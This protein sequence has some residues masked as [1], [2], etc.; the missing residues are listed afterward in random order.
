MM[1]FNS[2]EELYFSWFLDDLIK[3]GII[4]RYL[5]ESNSFILS[6]R[7]S[8]TYNKQLVTK[9]KPIRLS[10]LDEHIYTPDFLVEWNDDYYGIFFR[11]I[12]SVNC[13]TKPPFFSVRSK[14]NNLPYTF[15]EVK[16]NFDRNNMT[17]LFRINQKWLYDKHG[18]YVHLVTIPDLFKRMFIPER[19]FKTDS[20]RQLRKINFGIKK[21]DE[22]FMWLKNQQYARK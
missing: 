19:Y 18:L 16:G 5:Y 22:Y 20:N 13:F 7:K 3:H 15:F 10:L 8:Y 2:N 12:E 4:N 1:K 6:G 17:R 11:D 9:V 14:K 21:F